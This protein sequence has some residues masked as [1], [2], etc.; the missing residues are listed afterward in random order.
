M[1]WPNTNMKKKKIAVREG[2]RARPSLSVDKWGPG[3][4]FQPTPPVGGGRVNPPVS[5]KASA[6]YTLTKFEAEASERLEESQQE[7]LGFV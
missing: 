1:A 2:L 3:V 6:C 4:C 5:W 7:S